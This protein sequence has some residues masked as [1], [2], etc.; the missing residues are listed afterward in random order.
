MS[1]SPGIIFCSAPPL[2]SAAWFPPNE[3]V[4]AT[5]IGDSG[6]DPEINSSYFH[7]PPHPS[8][9]ATQIYLPVL[10]FLVLPFFYVPL[11]SP[12]FRSSFQWDRIRPGLPHCQSDGIIMSDDGMI[13]SDDGMIA[14]E[15]DSADA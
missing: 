2:V 10:H 1:Y 6:L 15:E 13:M 14:M 4:T 12:F 8:K 9:K 3:R 11:P 7:H 5:S